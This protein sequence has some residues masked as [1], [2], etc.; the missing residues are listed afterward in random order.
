MKNPKNFLQKY[1]LIQI[2]NC[3]SSLISASLIIINTIYTNRNVL[4]EM[5][6]STRCDYLASN[7][8]CGAWFSNKA[9]KHLKDGRTE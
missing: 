2:Y 7:P 3:I 1:L 4:N 5:T 8:P 9:L 6:V